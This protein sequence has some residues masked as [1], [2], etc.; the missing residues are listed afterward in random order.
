MSD[1]GFGKFGSDEWHSNK[2]NGM[3]EIS[4]I[5]W[6]VFDVRDILLKP[7]HSLDET[8]KRAIE[9]MRVH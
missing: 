4:A 2:I 8:K 5:C 3:E 6:Y 7:E 9:L 1:A